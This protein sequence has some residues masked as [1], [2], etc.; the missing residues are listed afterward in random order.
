MP[1]RHSDIPNFKATDRS[2]PSFGMLRLRKGEELEDG[3][4]SYTSGVWTNH[5]TEKTSIKIIVQEPGDAKLF[6]EAAIVNLSSGFLAFA[7]AGRPFA[8]YTNSSSIKLIVSPKPPPK[9]SKGVVDDHKD[10]GH[11]LC[12][13]MGV[14]QRLDGVKINE[15]EASATWTVEVPIEGG[16]FK[17]M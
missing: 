4:H 7:K 8:V 10:L 13:F 6:D 5:A 2:I 14:I 17:A 16:S 1:Y 3:S 12:H 9:S 11:L 15:E